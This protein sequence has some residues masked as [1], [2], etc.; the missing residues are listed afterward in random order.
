MSESSFGLPAID[1][2]HVDAEGRF[3]RG[4]LV[5]IVDEDLRVAVALEFDDHAGV[6]VG[7]IANIAD[8]LEDFLVDELGDPLDELC[9]VHAKRN[10]RDDNILATALDFLGRQAGAHAHRAAAR[11]EVRPNARAALNEAAR[12]K[13]RSF[14]VLHQAFDGDVGIVDLRADAVDHFAQIVRRDVRRHAD[15]NAGAAVDE[16]VRETRPGIRPARSAV[17]S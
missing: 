3:E 2:Q 12:R 8:A 17:S 11:L 4:V 5:E 15:G 13:V 7:F 6:L 14:D 10:L 1:R 9:A 16:Q